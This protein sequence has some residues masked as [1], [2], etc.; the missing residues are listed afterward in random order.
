MAGAV[1]KGFRSLVTLRNRCHNCE[2]PIA[3]AHGIYSYLVFPLRM[4]LG[5]FLR[6]VALNKLRRVRTEGLGG[7]METARI[8][9][10]PFINEKD[11]QFI[12]NGVDKYNI[13]ATSLPDYFPVNF[14]LRGEHLGRLAAGD[15]S[16]GR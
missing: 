8:E 10:E 3:A 4:H 1:Y 7:V 12:V 13:S 5:E 9:F 14:I 15:T 6:Q 16:V 11:R 2:R